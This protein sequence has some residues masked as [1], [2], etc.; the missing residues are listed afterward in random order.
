M[1]ARGDLG[2]E[3]PVEKIFLAQKMMIYKCNL[4]GKRVVTATQ[5]LESMIKSP[6]PTRAEATDVANAWSLALCSR[7]IKPVK[8]HG[9]KI[10]QPG[11]EPNCGLRRNW[12]GAVS[13]I[14]LL[15]QASLL[16]CNTFPD[17][18]VAVL[19][20]GRNLG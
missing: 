20:D 14:C 5:M 18:N 8:K 3:I 12:D 4:V 10:S 9:L 16:H 15:V 7:Y 19:K 1:V 13:H 6:R 2:I 11:L 17:E